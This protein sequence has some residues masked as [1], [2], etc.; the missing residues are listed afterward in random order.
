[1]PISLS[2]HESRYNALMGRRSDV[3]MTPQ[4]NIIIPIQIDGLKTFN[5]KLEGTSN[6]AYGMK[7]IVR[8]R[9]YCFAVRSRSSLRP[10]IAALP[11]A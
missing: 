5:I 1:M 3:A 4:A 6:R 11:T 2:N 8:H 7:K 10:M 9:L